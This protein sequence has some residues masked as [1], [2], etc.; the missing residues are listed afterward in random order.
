MRASA[1]VGHRSFQDVRRADHCP[2]VTE[3]LRRRS[4]SLFLMEFNG[5][6]MGSNGGDDISFR[7]ASAFDD[8]ER[9]GERI[10]ATK[11]TQRQRGRYLG[12][13][14]PW[15]W[16]KGARGEL[17]PVREQQAAIARM[18]RMR[19]KGVSLRKIK[20]RMADEGHAITLP[21]L[22]RLTAQHRPRADKKPRGGSPP[23]GY[24]RDADGKRLVPVPENDRRSRRS[25][26]C[27]P[28]G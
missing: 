4:V 19:A 27:V 26:D 9:V 22:M 20:E 10:R 23:F 5:G 15:G 13:I 2:G 12:G 21:T 28:R 8:H 6:N 11:R 16:I 14:A 25:T 1:V 24:R 3:A 7:A 18:R 17:V